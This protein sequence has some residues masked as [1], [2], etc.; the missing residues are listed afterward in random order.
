M[1]LL[2]LQNGLG[3]SKVLNAT[4][5]KRKT[6]SKLIDYTGQLDNNKLMELNEQTPVL[7]GYGIIV[8][9]VPF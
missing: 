1:I 5:L 8:P 9:S 3:K 4:P 2:L 7:S 6:L